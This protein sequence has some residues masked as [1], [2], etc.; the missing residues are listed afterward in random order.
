MDTRNSTV[1][2]ANILLK[3]QNGN[4]NAFYG[5]IFLISYVL[6]KE[7][8]TGG[9]AGGTRSLPVVSFSALLNY[10]LLVT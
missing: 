9:N 1:K 8:V 2:S 10:A 4:S 5:F 6:F 7:E 3:R